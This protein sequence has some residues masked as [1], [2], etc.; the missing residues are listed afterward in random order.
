MEFVLAKCAEQIFDMGEHEK[1]ARFLQLKRLLSLIQIE[2]VCLNEAF[3]YVFLYEYENM[4]A[5]IFDSFL[6]LRFHRIHTTIWINRCTL[7]VATDAVTTKPYILILQKSK[8]YRDRYW[9]KSSN[10][11]HMLRWAWNTTVGIS[12]L[13]FLSLQLISYCTH[14]I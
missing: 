2:A 6:F 9:P 5:V 10:R 11:P 4:S 7:N 14:E 3:D 13:S 1:P 12:L 8:G